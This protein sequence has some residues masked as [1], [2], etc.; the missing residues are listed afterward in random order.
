MKH[1]RLG[2]APIKLDNVRDCVAGEE[3]RPYY[4]LW[5]YVIKT[6]I[7]DKDA[8]F[9][10]GQWFI[11]ICDLIGIDENSVINGLPKELRDKVLTK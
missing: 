7:S 3:F 8:K 2:D 4:S 11:D 6:A 5:V 1:S 9:F 10:R